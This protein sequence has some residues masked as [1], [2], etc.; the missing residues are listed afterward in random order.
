MLLDSF[1]DDDSLQTRHLAGNLLQLVVDIVSLTI[2]H[3]AIVC[4]E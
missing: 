2:V 1:K 3:H 4:E